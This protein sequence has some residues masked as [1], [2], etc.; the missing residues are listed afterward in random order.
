MT[1]CR[2]QPEFCVKEIYSFEILSATHW[3]SLSMG[4]V[5]SPSYFIDVG[6]FINKK[7]EV[8]RCYHNEIKEYP[9]ARSYTAVEN[10]AKYRG[11]TIGV[12]Y[13]EAFCV[14]RLI[15]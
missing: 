1:A 8:L 11:N 12:K 10:L 2:P 5:F 14:E 9:H 7:I 6:D 3:Q 13:A 15:K 4:G